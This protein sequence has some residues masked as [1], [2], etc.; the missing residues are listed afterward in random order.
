MRTVFERVVHHMNNTNLYLLGKQHGK[1]NFY[2][3]VD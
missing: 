1:S 2:Y 3:R